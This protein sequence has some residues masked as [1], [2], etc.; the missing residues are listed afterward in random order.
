M[1]KNKLEKI[2]IVLFFII[3]I[4]VGMYIK[5]KLENKQNNTE[6]SR[7]VSYDISNIPQYSGDIYVL[8][9]NNI[10]N[11]IEEDKNIEE[12]YSKL[13]DQRVR[14]GNNKDQLEKGK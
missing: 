2:G 13:K 14:N 11:F 10:P 3:I 12:Y 6:I 4:F 7:Q 5:T 8:V 9:N 1:N